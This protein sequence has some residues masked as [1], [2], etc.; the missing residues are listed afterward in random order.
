MMEFQAPYLRV[1]NVKRGFIDFSEIKNVGCTVDEINSFKLEKDDLLVVEGHADINEIG[2]AAIWPGQ[3][4][5]VLHQNHLLKIRGC[6]HLS[7]VVLEAFINSVFGRNYF[8]CHAKSTTGLNTINSTVLKNL[9]IP[10]IDKREQKVFIERK[11]ALDSQ[12]TSLEENLN[13]TRALQK[14]LIN[15]IF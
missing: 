5:P 9:K 1:A 11:M 8:I 15:Q 12:L 10:A 3:S 2:R 7:P 13:L 4:E 14:S 6:T